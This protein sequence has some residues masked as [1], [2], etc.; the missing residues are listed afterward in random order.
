[1]R[2]DPRSRAE[3]GAAND[4]RERSGLIGAALEDDRC[5]GP[6]ANREFDAS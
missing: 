3:Q 6:G 1:V 4:D 5:S 2:L